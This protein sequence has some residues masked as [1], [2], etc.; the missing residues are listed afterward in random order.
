MK[1]TNEIN[2]EISKY[3]TKRSFNYDKELGHMFQ[4]NHEKEV[5]KKFL[6]ISIGEEMLVVV[7]VFF[8]Y[9]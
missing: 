1:N 4:S 2:K 6:K 5:W 3:W 7:Q 8:Q 9:Y